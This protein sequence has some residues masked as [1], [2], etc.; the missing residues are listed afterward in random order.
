MPTAAVFR[1]PPFDRLTTDERAELARLLDVEF[2]PTGAT[3]IAADQPV[4]HL[5]IVIKGAV[6][7]R[8]GDDLI[9]LHGPGDTFDSRALMEGATGHAYVAREETLCH[10]APREATLRL[11]RRNARFGG[12]FYSDLGRRLDA[13]NEAEDDQRVGALTRARV[14]D[15]HLH[16][17]I[18]IQSS[19]TIEH[20]GRTMRDHDTNAL[21]VRDE[22]P[23]GT[24][25][26]GIV[27]GMNLS[28]ACVLRRMPIS[29]PVGDWANWD[30]VAVRPDSFI[31][32][33]M[34][35]MT[36]HNKR[37]LAVVEG[38]VYVGLI[39]EIDVLGLL[40]SNS[41]I[42]AG[43][44]DRASGIA[45]LKSASGE[46]VASVRRLRRQGMGALTIAEITSDL[47]RRLF[48]KLFEDLAPPA[49]KDQACLMV[50]G[51]EGRS[52]QTVR[53]DQDNGLI[54]T[55]P[56]DPE[57][58]ESFRAAFSGALQDFGFPACPGRV[59][60]S[61]PD[62]SRTLGDYRAAIRGY[63]AIPD[64]SAHMNVAIL[65][66]AQGV[67][68][69][70]TL[71]DEL[72]SYL[73]DQVAGNDAFLA[74]FA[75][76]IDAFA[77]PLGFFHS[78]IASDGAKRDQIDLK[79]G[80]VFPVVHGVRCL[81]LKHRIAPTGTVPRIEALAAA[82]ALEARFAADLANAFRVLSDIRLDTQL[83][84]EITG[85]SGSLV[86]PAELTTLERSLL[87]DIF[88]TVKQLREHIRL[89]FRPGAF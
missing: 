26:V 67:G 11:A 5:F 49:L 80:G 86:R 7:E 89:V 76:T 12:F 81:A 37:R 40:S 16:P 6:E 62:W 31:F 29:A 53:T 23:D 48:A 82:G 69:R 79:K 47:N 21:F 33:A 13:M 14:R 63:V 36:K 85:D 30:I 73:F 4:Q 42:L 75:R 41:M 18:F 52:E 65:L 68:G 15:A 34:V 43:R 9:A 59:M 25:R 57:A 56:V 60:V 44:I 20:A 46:I 24:S 84:G 3:L 10:L 32:D 77:T 22:G 45:E 55:G 58:L 54:L 1:D 2:F 17:A 28:K 74:H 27:T 39:E 83:R 38:D 64:A 35:Q 72:R 87:K 78:L 66:D 50:M 71:V 61:N 19:D 70:T 88:A 8:A 51:S